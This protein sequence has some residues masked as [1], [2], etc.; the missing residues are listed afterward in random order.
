MIDVVFG[1]GLVL[2][3][4]RGWMRG[5]VRQSI[6]LGVLIGGVFLGYRLSG[7]AGGLVGSMAGTSPTT[8]RVIGGILVFLAISVGAAVA[9]HILHWGVRKLPGLPT[10]NRLGGAAVAGGAWIL[11]Y[12]VVLSL[13]AVLPMPEAV[14]AQIAGSSVAEALTAPDGVA[15][16]FMAA[17]GGDRSIAS[18][19]ALDRV[20]GR[21]RFAATGPAVTLPPTDAT[22]LRTNGSSAVRLFDDVNRERVELD[23]DPLAW[24]DA[25]QGAA[26][27]RAVAAYESGR[28]TRSPPGTVEASLDG[29]G[30]PVV[31]AWESMV[32]APSPEGVHETMVGTVD[33]ME[34]LSD[35]RYRRLGVAVVDGPYGMLTVYVFAG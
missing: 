28:L 14:D 26:Q 1:A 25:L 11:V 27:A 12:T 2:L 17:L 18:A 23:L 5:L 3:V 19:L 6:E 22:D 21:Q 24:S 4:I 29:A 15:Q 32:M 7:A 33:E 34:A 30:I 9:S 20:A 35:N 8:S 10:L 16:A 31:V 13:A